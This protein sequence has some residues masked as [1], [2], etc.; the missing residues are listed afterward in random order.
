MN[1][2]K[3]IT[4][5]VTAQNNFDSAV[6]TICFSETALVFDEGKRITEKKK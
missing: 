6:D 1:L 5:I 2:P 4:D 3:I